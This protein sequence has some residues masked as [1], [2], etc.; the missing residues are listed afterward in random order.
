MYATLC[1]TLQNPAVWPVVTNGA[2]A[3]LELCFEGSTA[4]KSTEPSCAALVTKG[5]VNAAKC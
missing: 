3:T 1:E 4:P 2:N 5:T